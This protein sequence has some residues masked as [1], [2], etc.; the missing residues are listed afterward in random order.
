MSLK[1]TKK[2]MY[3]KNFPFMGQIEFTIE[4]MGKNELFE[5][6]DFYKESFGYYSK[7]SE[8]IEISIEEAKKLIKF[9]KEFVK[10]D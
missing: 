7:E 3:V 6:T 10:K 4:K 5:F 8:Q 9:L 1:Y 2:R